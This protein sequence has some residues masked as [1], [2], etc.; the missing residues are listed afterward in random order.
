MGGGVFEKSSDVCVWRRGGAGGGGGE[1]CGRR[2]KAPVGPKKEH[3]R[4][5]DP[6]GIRV[7]SVGIRLIISGIRLLRPRP[8]PRIN[9]K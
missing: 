8:N 9:Q 1:P 2:K 6:C 7:G 5:W 4:A 3:K